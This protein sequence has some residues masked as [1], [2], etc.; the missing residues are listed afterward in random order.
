M[1][2]Q[3]D[4]QGHT[5]NYSMEETYDITS[6]LTRYGVE[7]YW[8]GHDHSREITKYGGVTYIVVDSLE[9]PDPNPFYMIVNMSNYI[10]YDFISLKQP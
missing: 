2:K 1:F 8:S 9:D 7:M 6:L 5:S 4:S 3:D 10:S